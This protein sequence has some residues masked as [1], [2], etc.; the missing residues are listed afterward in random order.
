V[1]RTTSGVS[2]SRRYATHPEGGFQ[3]VR[4]GPRFDA[5]HGLGITES[6]SRTSPREPSRGV[7]ARVVSW[8]RLQGSIRREWPGAC[9]SR[10][11]VKAS[12][13]KS[14]WRHGAARCVQPPNS[15]HGK[16][17]RGQRPSGWAGERR[18]RR[19]P[20]RLG[21]HR[22]TAGGRAWRDRALPPRPANTRTCARGARRARVSS[23]TRRARR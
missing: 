16:R 23:R 20:A 11:G 21:C 17:I 2:R 4:G 14:P 22:R 15:A 18:R 8:L 12:A 3:L 10:V 7:G 9:T 13:W 6:F 1:P 19:R 5:S